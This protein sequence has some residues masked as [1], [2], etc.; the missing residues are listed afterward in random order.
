MVLGGLNGVGAHTRWLLLPHLAVC[1][2]TFSCPVVAPQA[3]DRLDA[4]Q[5]VHHGGGHKTHFPSLPPPPFR[6]LQPCCKWVA[7]SQESELGW[8]AGRLAPSTQCA[9]WGWQCPMCPFPS[10]WVRGVHT[11]GDA[12][13]MPQGMLCPHLL[14]HL[15]MC[16]PY[17]LF[18]YSW[19]EAYPWLTTPDLG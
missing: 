12:A 6:L 13:A 17:N 19:G 3:A 14:G 15:S 1:H 10:S 4:W 2:A 8:G 18:K 5:I 16:T 11:G 7:A 9:V